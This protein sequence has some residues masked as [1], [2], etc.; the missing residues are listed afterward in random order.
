VFL[1][2]LPL[3]L[4]ACEQGKPLVKISPVVTERGVCDG[5][6]P[7]IDN[8][9]DALLVDGGPVSVVAGEKLIS[10]FDAGC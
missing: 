10:G 3:L 9:N 7:L 4:S 8:L 5:L 1:T 2:V 6:S